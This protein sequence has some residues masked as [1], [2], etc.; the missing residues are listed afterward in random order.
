[1]QALTL[2]VAEEGYTSEKYELVTNFPK[3]KLSYLDSQQTLSDT[4]LM[5]EAIF[6][7]ERA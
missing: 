5:Q 7:Q 4:G 1:M 2:Y 6:V 3:R